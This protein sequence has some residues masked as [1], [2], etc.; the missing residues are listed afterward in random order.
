MSKVNPRDLL[1]ELARP[2]LTGTSGATEV[3]SLI[4]DRFT[5]LGFETREFPFSFSTIPGRFAVSAAGAVLLIGSIATAF[6]LNANLPGIALLILLI[7]LFL[8]GAIGVLT[9][10]LSQMLPF[11]KV[12]TANLLFHQKGTRPRFLVMAH[13]DSKSQP[14][15]L[16]FRGPAIAIG[17]IAFL[18]Y[19]AFTIAVLIDPIYLV[20]KINTII[21]VVSVL[22]GVLLVF[23]WVDNRS[24]GAL[25]NASGVA[26]VLG[27][28]ERN[29][30]NSDVGYLITDAE[31]M[32]L[33]GARDIAR[34]LD[35]MIG[36][37]NIDCV[38]DDGPYNV[39]ERFGIPARHIAPHLVA[40]LLTAAQEM[41]VSARRRSVPFGILVD[42]IPLARRH[43]PSVTL[44]RG[45]LRSLR[46]VHLPSD[47]TE[48]MTG[49]GIEGAVELIDRAL[50]IMRTQRILM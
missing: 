36:I 32:G 25:D 48:A 24:P 26:T 2:R 9:P 22:A 47:S 35:P 31:E 50:N 21:A 28:A 33:L 8:V 4:R 5:D 44:M 13:F 3:A 11:K 40:S 49:A 20:P 1:K 10:I 18:A 43:L 14:L 12:S 16:A 30:N 17:I 19:F 42:H 23:C 38:D 7:M 27:V 45:G 15:P 46:R 39:L 29:A 37:I 34:K 41:D 6:L